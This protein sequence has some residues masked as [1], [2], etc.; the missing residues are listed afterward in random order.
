MPANGLKWFVPNATIRQTQYPVSAIACV[1]IDLMLKRGICKVR[2][3]ETCGDGFA[4]NRVCL[5][6]E[7]SQKPT[8]LTLSTALVYLCLRTDDPSLVSLSS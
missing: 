6:L 3:L 1:P 5:L 7:N 4:A 2:I 8:F